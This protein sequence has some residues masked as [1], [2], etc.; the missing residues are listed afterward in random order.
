[1]EKTGRKGVFY[2]IKVSKST[3]KEEKI[4][5]IQYYGPDKKRHLE[6]VGSSLKDMTAAKASNIR[7]MRIMGK[8]MSNN[9]KREVQ[10]EENNIWT[11]SRLW[12]EYKIH[13]PN[14]KGLAVDENRFQNYIE[15]DF[16]NVEP[17]DI[18]YFNVAKLRKK[19][20][21]N[22]DKTSTERH[23]LEIL[24]RI[25]N[26]GA[27]QNLCKGLSF[28]I[29]MP[30][31]DNIKTEDLTP[32]Q[33]SNLWNAIEQEENIQG[34]NFVKMVLF[35]G[36]RRGELFKLQW[37]DINFERGFIRIKDPKGGKSQEIPLSD[38]ARDLLLN[39]E[40]PYP[41]SPYVFP[42][43]DGNQRVEIKRP[44]NRIREK[45]GLP[46][47]FRPLHGLRHVYAS[48]LASSGK[49]DMYTLQK[50]LTHKSPQMTQRYAHLRDDTL[51]KAS[52]VAVDV[53][54]DTLNE[55]Q[56]GKVIKMR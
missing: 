37:D 2:R 34:K 54:Q 14:L 5:Y 36:M 24:R 12:K 4:F 53:I 55:S 45:A 18:T 10:K 21:K 46:K 47:D 9:E 48:M 11:I 52:Q 23:V 13:K 8:E 30:E 19:I 43:R 31:V 26:F 27:N 7:A 56:K 49:V 32:E 3:K 29:Q 40:Q 1:M 6:V 33:F 35:T 25:C 39:H 22:S 42:G 17:K 50:L 16:K 20:Q 15:P 41:H 38:S 51:K 28:T 44:V